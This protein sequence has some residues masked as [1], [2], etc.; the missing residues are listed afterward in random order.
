[1]S[2][3]KML[4]MDVDGTLTDGKLYIS[5]SGEEM[6]A[7]NVK[8]GY[9]I[10]NILPSMGII[11]VIITGRKSKIVE[12]RA[13]EL[14]ILEVHQ[15]IV[16]K[17]ETYFKLLDSYSCQDEDI[18]YMGDDIND[19]PILKRAGISACPWDASAA[20]KSVCSYVM[21]SKGGEGAVSEFISHL[22]EEITGSKLGVL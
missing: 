18:A 10:K 3:V 21:S 2:R 12:I 17:E 14:G 8:D 4:I 1:M 13:K 15:G 7:F 19:I 11:P 6:K 16:N 22:H 9:A 20:V 5:G